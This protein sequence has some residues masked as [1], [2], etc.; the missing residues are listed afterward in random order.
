MVDVCPC[1][2][3]AVWP[4]LACHEVFVEIEAVAVQCRLDLI[5]DRLQLRLDSAGGLST[6]CDRVSPSGGRRS[7]PSVGGDH[8]G[9]VSRVLA[10]H[11][12]VHDEARR[13]HVFCPCSGWS[14]SRGFACV[15]SKVGPLVVCS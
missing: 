6:S 7:S 8:G 9:G 5:S 2:V 15:C 11:G 12:V 13:V 1:F 3:H 4:L 10:A 14:C